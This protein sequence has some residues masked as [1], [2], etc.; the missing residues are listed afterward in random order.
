MLYAFPSAFSPRIL[1]LGKQFE[2]QI[3]KLQEKICAQKMVQV[4]FVLSIVGQ[5][6]DIE[7]DAHLV[8]IVMSSFFFF[9]CERDREN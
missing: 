1:P 6:Q 8:T 2:F 7:A 9:F 4:C 5:K 3:L